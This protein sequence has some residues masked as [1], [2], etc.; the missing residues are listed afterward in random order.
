MREERAR[1]EDSFFAISGDNGTTP[2]E[3]LLGYLK[4]GEY[5]SLFF[6]RKDTLAVNFYDLRSRVIPL[7]C[8]RQG[9]GLCTN[10]WQ[11]CLLRSRQFL[12]C[13]AIAKNTHQQNLYTL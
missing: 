10:P 4:T 5:A 3:G 7:V 1:F 11:E 6:S 13:A 9:L 2:L 12:C 8:S